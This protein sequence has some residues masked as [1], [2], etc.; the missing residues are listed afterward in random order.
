[1]ITGQDFITVASRWVAL[2]N[3]CEPTLRSSVSRAYYGAFHCAVSMLREIGVP[4]PVSNKNKHTFVQNALLSSGNQNAAKAGSM[5][6][7]LHEQR[8]NADYDIA[9][10]FSGQQSARDAVEDATTIRQLLATCDSAAKAQ[11]GSIIT[12]WKIRTHQ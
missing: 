10:T 4:E 3:G 8:K 7:S 6:A 2:Q 12:A 9:S 11:I 1:M 5:L